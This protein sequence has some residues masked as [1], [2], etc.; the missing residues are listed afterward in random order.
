LEVR[1]WM[2]EVL[3]QIRRSVRV[4]ARLGVERLVIAA[5]HGHLF[6]DELDP[7]MLMDPP[8]GK[9]VELHPRVW[10]GKGGQTADG[11]VR[12]PASQL[13]L[14]G[15]LE[16]AFPRGLACFRVKGGVG[17]YLHGGISLQEMVVPVVELR[18]KATR[19]PGGGAVALTFDKPA[20]TNRF[21]S[22]T[23]LLGQKELFSPD[24]VR[25]RADVVSGKSEAG[26]C[27][28]AAYGYAEGAREVTLQ[29]DR[30][31]ALTFMLTAETAVEK[32]TVRLVDCQTGLTLATVADV[33]VKLAI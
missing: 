20:I 9:T 1:R 25:V 28:M 18:S 16:L 32:V 12:L 30:A 33:P 27:A 11:Y 26:F 19:R 31:N 23:A 21:F 3:D 6:V 4:L 17:S 8:G 29:R 15:E 5:D 2:D 7:G 24:S 22:M 10:I 13:E 14:E